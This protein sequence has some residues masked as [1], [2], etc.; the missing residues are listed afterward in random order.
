MKRRLVILM[1]FLILMVSLSACG[2]KAP[3]PANVA[4]VEETAPKET[5]TIPPDEM[6]TVPPDKTK[7]VAPDE[8]EITPSEADAPEETEEDID[9]KEME[10][11]L[12]ALG[13]MPYYGDASKCKMTA[14]QA[15]A[16]AQLIADG[17]AGD[18]SFRSGYDEEIYNIVSWNEPFHINQV[19][20]FTE[21][22]ETDRAQVILGDFSAD[23][24][25]YLYI[26]SSREPS[27]FEVYGWN[28]SK[29]VLSACGEKYL[30]S[31]YALSE[32]DDGTVRFVE[33]DFNTEVCCGDE[34]FWAAVLQIEYAFI[35]SDMEQVYER[36]LAKQ[37][38]YDDSG[39]FCIVENG[40]QTGE[41]PEEG[42]ESFLEKTP[43]QHTLPYKCFYEVKPCTLEEMLYYLNA[44]AAAM[45][46]E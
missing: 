7:N 40:E 43:H 31:D 35:N 8:T 16:Y 3:A 25:P 4:N 13:K 1:I 11:L 20:A 45:S 9:Q 38:P 46:D 42:Y 14:E 37:N 41:C 39:T 44:Y 10:K 30:R 33:Q 28:E 29:P 12:S 21:G 34:Y 17:L 2:D 15:A 32:Q 22:Y 26:S 24:N 23:G 18:F 6:E 27:S 36:A 5:K 19:D